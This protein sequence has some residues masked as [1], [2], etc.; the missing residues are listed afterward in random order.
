MAKYSADPCSPMNAA[1]SPA[2]ILD[3]LRF[4]S[5]APARTAALATRSRRASQ[6]SI[7]PSIRSRSAFNRSSASSLS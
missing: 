7:I 2:F 5:T 6:L 3:R 4:D 1:F